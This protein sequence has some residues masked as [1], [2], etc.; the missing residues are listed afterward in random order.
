MQKV[1][2][3]INRFLKIPLIATNVRAIPELIIDGNT[4][5]LV[6]P[7]NPEE[8]TNTINGLLNDDNTKQKLSRNGFE[9]I[10]KNFSWDVLLE[11]YIKLY[12][13]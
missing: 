3:K 12:E 9:F 7:E 8:L 11:E 1:C 10:N 6:S 2:H 4:G 5:L 13:Q